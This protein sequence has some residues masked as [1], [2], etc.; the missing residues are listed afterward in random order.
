MNHSQQS[1]Y[2]YANQL[3]LKAVYEISTNKYLFLYDFFFSSDITFHAHL[4]YSYG[5]LAFLFLHNFFLYFQCLFVG[6]CVAEPSCLVEIIFWY[7]ICIYTHTLMELSLLWF[8]SMNNDLWHVSIVSD[9]IFIRN[10]DS[11]TKKE[12]FTCSRCGEKEEKNREKKKKLFW[13][14]SIV[15]KKY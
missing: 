4:K 5:L 1:V 11:H 6:N 15:H 14:E 10:G 12:T 13:I 7:L 9:T 2:V 8:W 3:Q